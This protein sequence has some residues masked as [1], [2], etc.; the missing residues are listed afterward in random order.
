ME[1]AQHV[2]HIC[3]A[4]NDQVIGG[5]CYVIIFLFE[6]TEMRHKT[7]TVLKIFYGVVHEAYCFSLSKVHGLRDH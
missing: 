3:K 1:N 7:S 6:K 5:S 4:A 2:S